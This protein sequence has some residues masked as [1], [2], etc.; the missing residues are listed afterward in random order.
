MDW[1]PAEMNYNT[2]N[3]DKYHHVIQYATPGQEKTIKICRCW[4]AKRFPYCDD[5]HKVLIEAGDN[6]GPYVVKINPGQKAKTTNVAA[7]YLQARNAVPKTAAFFALGFCSVGLACTAA[8]GY[9]KGLRPRV[10]VGLGGDK[11][12]ETSQLDTSTS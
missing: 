11:E 2:M 8:I 7:N 6:V 1:P 3:H 5:T 10:E 12:K 9:S 4:Q